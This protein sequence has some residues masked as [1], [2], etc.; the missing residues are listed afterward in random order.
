MKRNGHC[1]LIVEDQARIANDLTDILRSIDFDTRIAHNKED[2][3]ALL[4]QEPPCVVLLD[5]SIPRTAR[6]IKGRPAVGLS[7]LQ[8]IRARFGSQRDKKVWIPIVVVSGH[9]REPDQA[10]EIMKLHA[11]DLI[12]KPYDEDVVVRKIREALR[13]SGREAHSACRLTEQV[14][15]LGP[16]ESPA[17]AKHVIGIPGT[18]AKKQ[19]IV[20]IGEV[21]VGLSDGPL[22]AMLRLLLAHT[23]RQ[24]IPL[25]AFSKV[26]ENAY[27]IVTRLRGRCKASWWT[28]SRSSSMP[29]DVMHCLRTSYW[30]T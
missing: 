16:S 30:A 22:T 14:R 9:A 27:K 4:E 6:D 19:T 10:V 5:L 1:A 13:K 2:A 21:E 23:Q 11:D 20:T 29:M 25:S 15:V 12:Q 24:P 26:D 17:Q 3:L 18:A 8:D 28:R 7:L